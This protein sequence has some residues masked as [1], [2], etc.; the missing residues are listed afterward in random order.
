[1]TVYNSENIPQWAAKVEAIATAIARQATNDMLKD[2]EIVP[3]ISRGGSRVRGTIPRNLGA[4]AASLQSS[5]HGSSSL[6]G[7]GAD[8]Y[9]LIAGAMSLG[10]VA[11]FVWGGNIAPYARPV[12][13]GSRNTPGTYWVD[14]AAGKWRGYVRASVTKARS[15]IR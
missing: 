5:L 15:A 2:I 11:E 6:S 14:V 8:S 12:H 3:G 4:L 1:M 10:D 7:R 13:Y 9:I